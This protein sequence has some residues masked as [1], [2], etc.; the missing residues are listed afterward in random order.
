MIGVIVHP[1]VGSHPAMHIA[2][3]YQSPGSAQSPNDLGLPRAQAHVDVEQPV[4]M[5]RMEEP[6]AVGGFQNAS[7]CQD[8]P[9]CSG[10]VVFRILVG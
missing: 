4:D 1:E 2:A 10:S 9:Q 5:D 8:G 7:G 3:Y 6:V